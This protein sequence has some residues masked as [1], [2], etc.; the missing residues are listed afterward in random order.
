MLHRS[1][2]VNRKK[3]IE[4]DPIYRN[5]LVNMLVDRILKNGK[6]SLAYQIFYQAMKRIRQKTN[7]NP[8]SVL[9]QAVRGVTPDVVTETKRVGGS[10]YRVPVEVVPAEGKASAIR[11]SLIACRKRSGRS[12]AL[13]SSDESMDAARNSGSAIRKKEETHKVAEANKAFAH[14]R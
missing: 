13:R 5:R 3:N 14:F 10:T 7:R 12:M 11:W 9:R 8:L 6:K 1:S 4:S 2:V